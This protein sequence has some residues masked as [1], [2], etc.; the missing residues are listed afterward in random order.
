VGKSIQ[1]DI[2]YEKMKNKSEITGQALSVLMM[3]S[4]FTKPRTYATGVLN[5]AKAA[6]EGAGV[7]IQPPV[8]GEYVHTRTELD[9]LNMQMMAERAWH[10]ASWE[11]SRPNIPARDAQW[12]ET[13]YL[14]AV[15]ELPKLH[16]QAVHV[17]LPKPGVS[18]QQG[19][20]TANTALPGMSIF[21]SRDTQD[22]NRYTEPLPLRDGR[23]CFRSQLDG[24]AVSHM[25]CVTGEK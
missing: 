14:L 9:A 10:K 4:R 1:R 24:E 6:L 7:T 21:Y 22:W 2:Y 25:Q 15:R 11:G 8:E 20:I 19:R 5:N 16:A 23:F 18:M 3:A 13:A 17:Y 12:A